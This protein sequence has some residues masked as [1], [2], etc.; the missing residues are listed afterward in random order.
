MTMTSLPL[1]DVGPFLEG[2]DSARCDVVN[3]VRRAC[4]EI[5]FFLICGH[6]VDQELIDTTYA[7]AAAFF[8]LPV[9]EKL[10]IRQPAPEVSRGYTPFKGETLSASIGHA[11]PP[12]LKEMIDMGPIEVPND[13]YFRGAQAG[14]HFDANLW[15]SQP[16]GFEGVM[17]TYY[18][19][20]NRLAE[21]LMRL[22]AVALEMPEDFFADKLDKNISALRVIC[23]PEQADA[24]EPGQL[25]SGAH[26][27]Y[28]TLTILMSDSAA[29]G[30]QV[31]HRDGY[32]VDVVPE[33][34]TYIVNIGDIMQIWTNDQWVSTLH[35]VVNPAVDM[36]NTARRH[37]IVFFHQ[38]NYDAHIVPLPTCVDAAAKY[39]P[40]SYGQHWQSKWMATKANP[41][42]G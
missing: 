24:P 42:E 33:P 14:H 7:Q 13:D 30:L 5:G 25:R 8:R 36:A 31:Q 32:W 16:V 20:L 4:E 41:A 10:K 28:G 1:I 18:R 29:G 27:D 23:Y 34:G 9:E 37:S 38:P 17:R 35:R 40:I 15:P 6:G 21:D 39:A 12:D 3:A 19:R 2:S 22:F 11:A 26:T